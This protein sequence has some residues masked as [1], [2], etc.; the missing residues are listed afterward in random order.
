MSTFSDHSCGGTGRNGPSSSA[1]LEY[2]EKYALLIQKLDAH[3]ADGVSEH[4]S[5]DVH[6][7]REYVKTIQDTLTKAI[8]TKQDASAIGDL[9]S[10]T[11]AERT[12]LVAA[13]NKLQSELNLKVS[14]SALNDYAKTEALYNINDS[15]DELDRIKADKDTVELTYATKK[16]L[17]D[18][19][20]VITALSQKIV[21]LVEGKDLKVQEFVDVVAYHKTRAFYAGT[22]SSSST[23]TNGVYIL[24]QI[25]KA[26]FK[27]FET[28]NKNQAGTLYLKFVNNS[29][30]DAIINFT[31]T[32]S[33]KQEYN[34]ALLVT[35][36]RRIPGLEDLR[37]HI[38]EGT[39]ADTDGSNAYLAVSAARLSYELGG[40][41]VDPTTPNYSQY[42]NELNFYLAGTNFIPA[43]A[44]DKGFEI[45]NGLVTDICTVTVPNDMTSGLIT[46]N[47]ATD[48]LACTNL[49]D[50]KGDSLL[51]G[52][53]PV[54]GIIRWAASLDKISDE[55][56]PCDGRTVSL[57]DYPELE[58]IFENINGNIVLPTEDCSI[59]KVRG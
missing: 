23:G 27:G 11:T 40:N 2:A 42:T 15:L 38:V 49:V 30:F 43:D 26:A 6:K 21:P 45:P 28:P 3:I 58:N 39:S 36:S 59:I 54:G 32:W 33:A 19:D 24:G 17:E 51:N 34:G 37:F 16:A 25:S 8:A 50:L 5:V 48:T 20:E 7:V 31:A 46:S 12:T 29:D 10:L 57:E 22:G 55:Y 4:A 35:L 47:V 1:L 41:N 53:I 18:L 44:K 52:R 56:L 14:A 9:S 13:I